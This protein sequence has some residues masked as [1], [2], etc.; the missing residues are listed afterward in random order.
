M[1]RVVVTVDIDELNTLRG[2][3]N[4]LSAAVQAITPMVGDD[5]QTEAIVNAR[6]ALLSAL[7]ASKELTLGAAS[8]VP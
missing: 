4:R 2:A 3:V 1:S 5:L 8:V 7:K 6:C